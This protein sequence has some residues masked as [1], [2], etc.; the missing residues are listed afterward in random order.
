MGQEIEISKTRYLRIR[1]RFLKCLRPIL[2]DKGIRKSCITVIFAIFLAIVI[3]LV[4]G[5]LT[6]ILVLKNALSVMGVILPNVFLD[7]PVKTMLCRG[8][9]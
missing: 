9:L 4:S 5:T 6:K 8:L 2:I 1:L 7:A 3:A